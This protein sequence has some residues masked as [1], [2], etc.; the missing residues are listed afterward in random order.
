MK[1]DT[2]RLMIWSL[3]AALLAQ[4]G[5]PTQCEAA[6][7]F[8]HP[9][10]AKEHRDRLAFEGIMARFGSDR[11]KSIKELRELGTAQARNVLLETAL[12]RRGEG[13]EEWAASGYLKITPR[14]SEARWLFAAKNPAVWG[15][16]ILALSKANVPL[17]AELMQ[18]VARL[19]QSSDAR[20]RGSTAYYLNTERGSGFGHE[21]AEVVVA[22]LETIEMSTNFNRPTGSHHEFVTMSTQGGWACRGIIAAL[23]GAGG[24]DLA[25]LREST[26]AEAG[27]AKDC[28]LIARGWR[29]DRGV[30][31][32]LH[33][34]M[35]ESPL[36]DVRYAAV[37][38][39][40]FPGYAAADDLPVLG[41]VAD[42]DPLYGD[43]DAA[44]KERYVA[45][46]PFETVA[47]DRIYPVRDY[48]REVVKRF[49]RQAGQQ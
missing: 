48:A 46:M 44:T 4:A 21:K 14:P 35:R 37:N 20:L 45:V 43:L 32:E 16:A 22:S 49:P 7:Q 41:E 6:D 34:I 47:P 42:S 27:L 12:G 30:K 24:V 25:M 1:I 29:S 18:S 5:L 31:P 9:D 17:D 10:A 15:V 11:H 2:V 13:N 39:F 33:R 19:L 40:A 3:G 28:V 26:P 36:A 38:A 23:A 8:A